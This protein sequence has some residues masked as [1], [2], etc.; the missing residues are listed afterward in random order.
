MAMKTMKEMHS[1]PTLE[2]DIELAGG[3]RNRRERRLLDKRWRN[4]G[5]KVPRRQPRKATT[6]QIL[7]DE[8]HRASAAMVKMFTEEMKARS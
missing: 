7:A 8:V 5:V 3:P 4:Q 6:T 2:M 1:A